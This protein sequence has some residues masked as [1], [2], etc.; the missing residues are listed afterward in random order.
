MAG[1]ECIGAPLSPGEECAL[2]RDDYPAWC[3]YIAPLRL[4]Y[5]RTSGPDA[6]ARTW[7]A[8]PPELKARI[9]RLADPETKQH[10]WAITPP[11]ERTA[12]R[13]LAERQQAERV[14]EVSHA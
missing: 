14:E 7:R 1:A 6:Q 2:W 4:A 10:L 13:A 3:R 5:L 12:L 8:S 11:E 9:L